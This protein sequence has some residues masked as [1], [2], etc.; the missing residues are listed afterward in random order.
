MGIIAFLVVGLL[1]GWLAGMITRSERYGCWWNMLIGL[2]G[3][4]VGQLILE[5]FN[6]RVSAGFLGSVAIATMGAVILL[7]IANLARR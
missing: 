7:A 3:A 6:V 2:I 4:F 5:I 1:A